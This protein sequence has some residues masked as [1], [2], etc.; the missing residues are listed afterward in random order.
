MKKAFI[1]TCARSLPQLVMTNQSLSLSLNVLFKYLFVMQ[2]EHE[3]T[4][5][6]F[7]LFAHNKQAC[8]N[9]YFL[10]FSEHALAKFPL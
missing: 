4:A 10:I 1:Y 5:V 6:C 2:G 3:A 8:G 9:N 7:A